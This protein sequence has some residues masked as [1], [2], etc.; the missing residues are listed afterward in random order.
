[1]TGEQTTHGQN[2]PS[3]MLDDYVRGH[4]SEAGRRTVEE[5][6]ARDEA[7]ASELAFVRTLSAAVKADLRETPDPAFG[8]KRLSRAIEQEERGGTGPVRSTLS[9]VYVQS[10]LWRYAAVLLACV[11]TVQMIMLAMPGREP[12]RAVVAERAATANETSAYG[13]ASGPAQPQTQ[14]QAQAQ[15]QEVFRLT[16]AFVP[17]AA[18]QSIREVLHRVDGSIVAGPSANRLYQVA[19][20]TDKARD[21][22]LKIFKGEDAVIQYAGQ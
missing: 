13:M 6:A 12:G 15:A 22:A 21:L 14:A 7:V 10:A 18:E 11:V 8:W 2:I 1:M 19:F 5:A 9:S 16:V 3:Q 20:E 4:L 17:E